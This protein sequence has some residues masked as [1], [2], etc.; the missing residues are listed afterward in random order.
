MSVI[1]PL[2]RDVLRNSSEVTDPFLVT[3]GPFLAFSHL[4]LLLFERAIRFT[5]KLPTRP[6]H[7]T[8]AAQLDTFVCFARLCNTLA[9]VTA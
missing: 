8:T 7:H 6:I 5:Q 4:T 3:V 1:P 9:V 2:I